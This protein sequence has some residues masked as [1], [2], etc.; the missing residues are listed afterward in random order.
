MA[1]SR[2]VLNWLELAAT[3]SEGFLQHPLESRHKLS[4]QVVDAM[5]VRVGRQRVLVAGTHGERTIG[6]SW[7]PGSSTQGREGLSGG[8]AL[9]S[10]DHF[11]SCPRRGVRPG[12]RP[13]A[14]LACR[15][16]PTM[17]LVR[18]RHV[19]LQVSCR[20]P[21]RPRTTCRVPLPDDDANR[22]E[23]PC[24]QHRGWCRGIAGWAPETWMG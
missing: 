3:R 20:R 9:N 22:D 13:K 1:C 16:Q 11:A 10:D 2:Q 5:A 8:N 24:Q 19:Q 7:W 14:R 18:V 15:L 6:G 4:D 23:A 17:R 21:R 12:L